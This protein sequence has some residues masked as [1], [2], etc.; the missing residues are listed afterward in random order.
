MSATARDLRRCPRSDV[1]WSTH[2]P[3][4]RRC[5]RITRW[6]RPSRSSRML[7]GDSESKE[8]LGTTAEQQTT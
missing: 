7:T 8:V 2:A 6:S 1:S 3:T 5:R 4:C